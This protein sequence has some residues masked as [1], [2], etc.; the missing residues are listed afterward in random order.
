MHN[1]TILLIDDEQTF[2]EPLADALES[3]GHRVLKARTGHEALE[4][5][6]AG[7]S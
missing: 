6:R 4:I 1:K 3:E 5:L 7:E 2:L